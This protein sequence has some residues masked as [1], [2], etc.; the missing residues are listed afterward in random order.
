M[1][2]LMP[3]RDFDNLEALERKEQLKQ[4]GGIQY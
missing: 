4:G 3:L 1:K 2:L